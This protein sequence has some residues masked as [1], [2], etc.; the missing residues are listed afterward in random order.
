MDRLMRGMISSNISVHVM[1]SHGEIT[2]EISRMVGEEISTQAEDMFSNAAV[3]IIKSQGEGEDQYAGERSV[4]GFMNDSHAERSGDGGGAGVAAGREHRGKTLGTPLRTSHLAV[5]SGA[6]RRLV[7]VVGHSCR[8]SAASSW[9]G[10]ANRT[11][12]VCVPAWRGG[13]WLPAVAR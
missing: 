5:C 3:G 6:L 2:A 7:C 10:N 1:I 11:A 4:I 12:R 13:A 9:H 8:I